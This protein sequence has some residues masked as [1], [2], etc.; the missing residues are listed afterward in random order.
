LDLA[1]R[2]A[3]EAA[4]DHEFF[5][6][7]EGSEAEFGVDG[8]GVAGGEEP[9][10]G[11]EVGMVEGELDE[12]PGEAFAA[13]GFIDPDVAEVGE[14]GAVGD[15]AEEGGLCVLMEGAEEEGGVGSGALD[16]FE[17]D[18]GA[19]VGGGKPGMEAGPVEAGG[20]GGELV[21]A[22]GWGSGE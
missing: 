20:V 17:R 14:A 9:V 2:I 18:A 3:A 5:G 21:V 16:A 4:F 6:V 10:A 13:V 15:D 8:V 12:V 11:C 1:S 22:E 19:P 7:G